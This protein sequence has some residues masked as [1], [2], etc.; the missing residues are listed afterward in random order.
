[1]AKSI[2]NSLTIQ[3]SPKAAA[4]FLN[5]LTLAGIAYQE[6][7]LFSKG[8]K[9]VI[10]QIVESVLEAMPWN[11]IAKVLIAYIQRNHKNRLKIFYA[12]GSSLEAHGLSEKATV[13]AIDDKPAA[14][15]CLYHSSE[16]PE[17]NPIPTP[18]TNPLG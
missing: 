14:I 4:N 10:V 16:V 11:A 18:P 17:E 1:M 7:E 9:P 13:K 15:I 3:L 5:D 12:D 2:C 6:I 8:E